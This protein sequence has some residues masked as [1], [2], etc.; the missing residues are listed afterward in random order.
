M[1]ETLTGI[2]SQILLWVNGQHNEYWDTVMYFATRRVIWYPLYV[3]MLYAIYLC[4]GWRTM[5]TAFVMAFLA[6]LLADQVCAS[7]IR[8]Y[9]GRLR[10]CDPD[11]PISVCVHTVL[12]YRPGSYSFPSCHAANTMAAATLTS[13]LF[14]RWRYTVFAFA[15]AIFICY[16]RM[17]LGVH[18][19]GDLLAGSVAGCAA[20]CVAY[21]VTS[22][23]ATLFVRYVPWAREARQM[24]AT[25]R[26]GAPMIHTVT[27]DLSLKWRPS[28]LP[29]WV[30]SATF[31]FLLLVAA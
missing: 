8:P 31:V 27:G 17:Y 10:P 20:G 30:G 3:A 18:Y 6:V 22:V 11:N 16:T 7:V 4:Y 29:I 2:D 26:R 12:G 1:I 28:H 15:W 5:V 21:A 25:Y 14:K 19:P 23:C 24:V 13:L 9:V